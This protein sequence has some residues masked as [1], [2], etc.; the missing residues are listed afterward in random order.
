M[1]LVFPPSVLWMAVFTL[2][3]HYRFFLLHCLLD[4]TFGRM[5]GL[6]CLECHVWGSL[7][8]DW[9]IVV[10]DYFRLRND[11]DIDRMVVE[12][13][14]RIIQV[15]LQWILASC[16]ECFR[17]IP[18]LVLHCACACYAVTSC[19][20][21]SLVLENYLGIYCLGLWHV[22]ECQLIHYNP[23]CLVVVYLDWL[24]R[25][26]HVFPLP[27]RR[28]SWQLLLPY[29]RIWLLDASLQRYLRVLCALACSYC[30]L[31]NWMDGLV[32]LG[33]HKVFSQSHV[34]HFVAHLHWALLCYLILVA[35]Y[36]LDHYYSRHFDNRW[37]W[38]R[39]VADDC[40]VTWPDLRTYLLAV[41][42]FILFWMKL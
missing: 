18:E 39:V 7:V 38:Y 40:D 9:G 6:L 11:C 2:W 28:L 15:V 27:L 35:N 23:E 19:W 37:V 36:L 14:R 32:T 10:S 41:C 30:L 20:P 26:G 25:L 13:N 8:A 22:C 33:S 1:D 3:P 29:R 24:V 42:I 34:G 4:Q 16:L 5:D 17:W 31:P 21:K 12:H